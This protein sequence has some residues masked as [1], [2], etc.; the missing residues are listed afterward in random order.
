MR[1]P[2][3]KIIALAL[4]IE[5]I[6]LTAC[7]ASPP[8]DPSGVQALVRDMDTAWN[9]HDPDRMLALFG[10]DAT[11]VTPTGTRAEGRP[12]I[13]ALLAQPSPT[14][15]TRSRTR[16]DAVQWLRDDLVLI[17]AVQT[18]EGP[19]V[20]QVGAAEAALVAVARRTDGRW[21]LVSARPRVIAGSHA[22]AEEMHQ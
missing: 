3:P 10:E 9:A 18:L 8:S 22:Q 15:Q 6:A 2:Q 11:L 16:V 19:G 13:A 14:A 5:C 12:Q 21:V 7:G 17:D 4:T 20:A 1:T